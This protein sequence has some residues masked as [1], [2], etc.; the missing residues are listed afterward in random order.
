[1]KITSLL[2]LLTLPCVANAE[3]LDWHLAKSPTSN[4]SQIYGTYSAG[5]MDGGIKLPVKG[6]GYYLGGVHDN[7]AY[8]QPELIN[9]IKKLGRFVSTDLKRTL[10]IGDLSSP[11]GGPAPL[12]SSLHQSHQNGLDVD[13][14]F[15]AAKKTENADK[16]KQVLMLDS[17]WNNINSKYWTE[18]NVQILK[19]A[20]SF[21]EV[22]RIFVNPVIKKELCR[23]HS[24]EK[25]MGKIRGWWGH[26][27]HFHVRLKCPEGSTNCQPQKPVPDGDGCGEELA[28]WFSEEAK[29]GSTKE[30]RKYPELPKECEVVYKEE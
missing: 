20:A 26:A 4:Q 29:S 22:D 10:V 8:G 30:P 25:W 3:I 9:Y 5:C 21:E 23:E 19:E 15:R 7:R 24:G 11:R 6:A 17:S 28:W 1:M 14:W 2:L 16:I 12:F 18:D 13:I 27:E